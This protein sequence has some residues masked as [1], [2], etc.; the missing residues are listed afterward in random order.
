MGSSKATVELPLRANR[1]SVGM[2]Y[3]WTVVRRPA[4]S[5]AAVDSPQGTVGDSVNFTYKYSGTPPTF[6]ADVDGDYDLQVDATERLPDR[7]TATVASSS[8]GF[9]V[10][11]LAGAGCTALPIS[12]PAAGLA[13]LAAAL[14]R[15]R[16]N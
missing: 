5:T 6:K 10:S 15:R 13:L 1:N 2:D 9:R 11:T 7:L 12:A 14:L 16:R 3:K 8:A 4:G